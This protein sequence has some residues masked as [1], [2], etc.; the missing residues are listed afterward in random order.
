[1]CLPA[2]VAKC[3]SGS[4]YYRMTNVFR[5]LSE[6]LGMLSSKKVEKPDYLQIDILIGLEFE[7]ETS[8]M[9]HLEHDFVWC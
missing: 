2:T 5:S 8:K 7:E 9:L 1:M 6:T 3:V 4:D